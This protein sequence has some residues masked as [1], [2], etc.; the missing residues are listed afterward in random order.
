MKRTLKYL[1]KKEW[2]MGNGQCAECEGVSEDW[3]GH[4]LFL[5]SDLIGHEANCAVAELIKELGV[6]P[7][8]IG[9]FT[10]AVEYWRTITKNGFFSTEIKTTEISADR[11]RF[12]D[13]WKSNLS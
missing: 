13:H 3:L 7:L 4:P 10:S 1:L 9:D 8:Y 2:S 6:A 12:I 11:Q 5:T